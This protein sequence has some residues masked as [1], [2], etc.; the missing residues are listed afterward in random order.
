M[1]DGA[2][3][4]G[5]CREGRIG[6]QRITVT[7]QPIQQRLLRQDVRGHLEV[8][9]AFGNAAVGRRTALAAEATFTAGEDRTTD[10]PEGAL[11]IGC[12]RLRD[13]DGSLALIPDFHDLALGAG[14]A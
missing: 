12:R 13:D 6:V 5:R 10:G 2:G 11:I 3:K 8:G 7:T 9:V 4:P 1:Q 14:G